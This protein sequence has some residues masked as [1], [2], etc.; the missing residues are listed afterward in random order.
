MGGVRYGLSPYHCLGPNYSVQP[1][2]SGGT[3]TSVHRWEV[4]RLGQLNSCFY[5]PDWEVNQ[6]IVHLREDSSQGSFSVF[7]CL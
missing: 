5:E 4:S 3:K 6:F 7:M 2:H 1:S